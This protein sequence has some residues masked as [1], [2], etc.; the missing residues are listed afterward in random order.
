MIAA[1]TFG[2]EPKSDRNREL[3][4]DALRSRHARV[5]YHALG[6][7]AEKYPEVAGPGL[8]KAL[9]DGNISVREAAQ[10]YMAKPKFEPRKFYLEQIG[11]AM[12]GELVA[13]IAGL[14]E[15]GTK[16]DIRTLEQFVAV[17]NSPVRAAALRAIGK[18]NRNHD[19]KIFLGALC[20]KNRRVGREAVAALQRRANAIGGK[21]LWEEFPRCR[22]CRAKCRVLFLM[23]RLS[24]WESLG[25]LLIA[26]G[27]PEPKVSEQA[28]LYKRRLWQR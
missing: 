8:K 2:H 6:A 3:L 9:M 4:E 19:P 20:D 16:E 1:R 15:T 23:A 22:T 12:G 18:L 28:Q 21:R 11:S 17:P 24:K 13:G 27:D 7:L 10:F 14:G 25:Y 5:R 26:M